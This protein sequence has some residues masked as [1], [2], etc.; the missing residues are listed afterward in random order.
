MSIKLRDP[1]HNSSPL[2]GVCKIWLLSMSLKTPASH[3]T[4]AWQNPEVLILFGNAAG[5]EVKRER[6]SDPA[7]VNIF[8]IHALLK[9]TVHVLWRKYLVRMSDLRSGNTVLVVR[10]F[11]ECSIAPHRCLW[12]NGRGKGL[13][14]CSARREYC[15]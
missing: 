13:M 6:G 9:I 11:V 5:S 14:M 8:K 12:C 15:Y 4:I 2:N 3:V 10:S 1:T 7:L